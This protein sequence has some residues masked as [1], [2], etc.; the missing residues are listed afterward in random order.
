MRFAVLGPLQ[1]TAD[2]PI[3]LERPSHRRL[4]ALLVL[5]AD[6]P[7]DT[8]TLIERYW[9]EEPPR[10]ARAA[11][12]THLSQLRRRI[13]DRT[14]ETAG[15]G[16][17]LVLDGH[18]L[19]RD[20]FEEHA[21]AARTGHEA[22]A[23]ELAADEA[24]RALALW[25]GRPFAEL[26]DDPEAQPTIA[27]L[28]EL[29]L[30]LMELRAD[31][32]LS[33][34]RVE[35]ALP[36]L[37]G[38]AAQHPFRERLW[39]LLMLA[40]TR[41]GRPTEALDAYQA[42]RFTLGEMGLE[43]SPALRELEERIFREDPSL[44]P[45]R[46]HHNLPTPVA[47][48]IGRGAEL[49]ELRRLITEHRLVTLTGVGGA[50]KT[51]LA[52]EA[53]RGALAD[54]PD[55]V[56]LIDL[57]GLVQPELVVPEVA[58]TLGLRPER[59]PALEAVLDAVRQRSV[60]LLL[61]NCEHLVDACASLA[62]SIL[63]AA[64]QTTVLATSREAL[65]LPGETVY[66]VP[67]LAVPP[68]TE[69]AVATLRG[70]DAV[71]LFADRAAAAAP[72]FELAQTT[73]GAV[74]TICRRLD[75]LP[76]AIELAAARI[77][78]LAP[79]ALA[80]RLADHL[81]LLS[82][83]RPGTR[84]RHRTLEAAIDW[85]Y[86]LLDERERIV[87]A[88]LSTFAGGWSLEAAEAV[89]AD[90][91]LPRNE[92]VEPLSR[93]VE[94]SLVVRE[95][96][97]DGSARY[98]ML[99]TLREFARVRLEEAS[100]GESLARRHREWFLAL[101]EEAAEHLD[102]SDQAEWLDR[103]GDERDNLVAALTRS[104][105][106]GDRDATSRLAE[107]L[108]WY[109][110]KMGQHA[111]AI[112]DMRTALNT[113]DHADDPERAAALLVRLAGTGYAIGD[114][115]LALASA[116]A[117]CD[118]L[119]GAPP[120]AAKVRALSE[121]A[122]LYLRIVQQEPE[123]AVAAS[124]EAIEAARAIGDRF[125]ESHALRTLGTALSW[126]GEIDEGL[127]HLRAALA[128]AR[129]IDNPTAIL[130]V[131]MRLYITLV[132]FARRDG[133]AAE[134]AEDALA[135]L[136]AGGDRWAGAANLLMWFAYGSLRGGRWRPAETMLDRSAGFHVEGAGR[137]S[138]HSL[139]AM[140][141]WM[142]GRL[143]EAHAELALLRSTD[144]TPRYFRLLYPLEAEIAA[145]EGRL[146]DVRSLAQ[147][148]LAA[149]LI[150]AE[151][152][153]RA[154]TLRA[155]VRAEVDAALAASSAARREHLR[156]ARAAITLIRR[157][158]ARHAGGSLAGIQLEPPSVSLALAEAELTRASGPDAEAWR[159]AA[160]TALFAYWRLYADWRLAESLLISGDA[161]AGVRELQAARAR[162]D[163]LGAY[164]VR[165]QLDALARRY[166][167]SPQ[168]PSREHRPIGQRSARG[169]TAP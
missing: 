115:A 4:L 162:A 111:I 41:A 129:D 37:E 147:E 144:P 166:G 155:L 59:R 146:V 49:T 102:A 150:P 86:Q 43:P 120:S 74:A 54:H 79:Q 29:R 131:Y 60:L 91:R 1:V 9:A 126:A 89:C 8:D 57:A 123:P 48:F 61:D 143:T 62:S 23:W 128:I 159:T 51:R 31:A 44:V 125:A 55:G 10:T 137:M 58:A 167:I 122:S 56:Y 134:M 164:L 103:L 35:R 119:D 7:L 113:I 28:E 17:R 88:R 71:R 3:E 21:Q 114:E 96:A 112:G 141:R 15:A 133:E 121:F 135:W 136:D 130:G 77:R 140:L 148:H 80:D 157:L 65:G 26:D 87:F 110:S 50:G 73:V 85:S 95:S 5:E 104:L 46:V 169:H 53:A 52:V 97:A 132:D 158:V 39:E 92:V 160:S 118:L 70:Y 106:S 13:G 105:G 66:A 98:R 81:G 32:L 151:Q 139:R 33:I 99:E 12:Q 93:L 18:Q 11:L 72:G 168:P 145:D 2:G 36:D 156:R 90:D 42:L 154:G 83:G 142:Q 34:G 78:S 19:D 84:P 67:P 75:G 30:E 16:Y 116:R 94:R 108:A 20:E 6:R 163:E 64:P 127:E 107:V 149:E 27:R 69:S 38:V 138:Y 101:A 68:P 40:R 47:S 161:A 14:I 45:P 25:R 117:A 165:G 76:L 152:A 24:E 124:R 22:G 109:R 82:D 100:E 153:T 63:E